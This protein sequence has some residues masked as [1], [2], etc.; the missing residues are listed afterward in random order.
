MSTDTGSSSGR[1]T[2][3]VTTAHLTPNKV[4]R[5]ATTATQLLD[6]IHARPLDGAGHDRLRAIDTRIIEELLA[7]LTP[8][9]RQELQRLALPLTR[10]TE[11]SDTELRLAHAQLVGWLQGLLQTAHRALSGSHHDAAT[12]GAPETEAGTAALADNPANRSAR[13]TLITAITRRITQQ[14]LT[15]AQAAARL[16]LTGPQVTQLFHADVD[17]FTLDELV[18]L[19]PALGLILQVVPES[20]PSPTRSS[21]VMAVQ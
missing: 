7:E 14:R 8:D 19:L 6:E 4:M 18:N 21:Q 10:H 3:N 15:A 2:T 5:I 9:L 12:D 1:P 16:H 11:H 13:H 17:A 20:N